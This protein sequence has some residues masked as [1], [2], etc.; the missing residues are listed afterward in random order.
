MKV[1]TRRYYKAIEGQNMTGDIWMNL[2]TLGIL[3][4]PKC[5]GLIITPACDLANA[6][7]ETITYLPIIPIKSWLVSRSFY[8]EIRKALLNNSSREVINGVDDIL[9]K[10]RPPTFDEV[11]F[12]IKEISKVTITK[13]NSELVNKIKI[14]LGLLKDIIDSKIEECNITL[15]K[16]FLGDKNYDSLM[17]KLIRNSHSNDIHF[18]PHDKETIEWSSVPAHSVVLFR[19]P[20]TVPIE[21]FDL[22]NDIN[23]VDWESAM[24]LMETAYPIA[25]Q[26]KD[27]RPLRT[28]CISSDFLSDLL[29]RFV[30]L[31]VRIGSPDFTNETINELIKDI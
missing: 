6:K 30:G 22:A 2:P 8:Y 23:C 17:A 14:G 20:I 21:I 12:L 15:L 16:R 25:A 10:N 19:Y 29:T 24:Q 26:F 27:I 5:S 31:Y 18:L 13:K 1:T 7:V 4:S 28:L 11:E 3:K 9:L